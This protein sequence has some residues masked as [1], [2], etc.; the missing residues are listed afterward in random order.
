MHK[1][2][3]YDERNYCCLD[4]FLICYSLKCVDSIITDQGSLLS[5]TKGV[6]KLYLNDKLWQSTFTKTKDILTKLL[7]IVKK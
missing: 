5:E 7:N 2:T 6:N 3:V 4:Y 1:A